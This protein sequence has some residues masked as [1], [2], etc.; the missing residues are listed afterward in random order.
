LS[1]GPVVSISA[2]VDGDVSVGG[3]SISVDTTVGFP[4]S[5]VVGCGKNKIVYTGKTSTSFT[6]VTGVSEAISDGDVIKPYVVEISVSEEGTDPSWQ[7]LDENVDYNMQNEHSSI[8]LFEST[9]YVTGYDYSQF[10]ERF[11]KNRFRSTYLWGYDTI[12]ADIKKLCLML[13]SKDIMHLAVRKAHS[14]GI[15]NYRPDLVDIDNA[16]IE[17][18]IESYKFLKY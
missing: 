2:V 5:G 8:T 14:Q 10:P 15:N 9:M 6:G 7:V 13:A 4:S 3:V 16:W 1:R 11:V 17:A 12:P 18:T